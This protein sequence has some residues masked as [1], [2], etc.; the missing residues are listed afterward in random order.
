M[1]N[2][3]FDLDRGIF[4]LAFSVVRC[5]WLPFCAAAVLLLLTNVSQGYL[6]APLAFIVLRALTIM[7][8]GYSAYRVLL[9][10]GR[11]AG[12]RALDTDDG[13]IPWRYAG[14]MLMVLAPILILGIV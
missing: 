8:V 3:K 7:V 1:T 4:P 10:G 13:R 9:T 11:V 6:Y 14:V 12:W 2:Q 5:N